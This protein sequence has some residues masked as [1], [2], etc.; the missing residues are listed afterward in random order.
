[1]QP[2]IVRPSTWS[3]VIAQKMIIDQTCLEETK[4][5]HIVECEQITED[6]SGVKAISEKSMLQLHTELRI[7]LQKDLMRRLIENTA[8]CTMDGWLK[9]EQNHQSKV[10]RS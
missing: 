2:P 10:C 1:M 6:D 3:S 7:V 4:Q 8:Y 5:Q 9:N